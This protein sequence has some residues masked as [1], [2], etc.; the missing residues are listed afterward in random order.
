MRQNSINFVLM[1]SAMFFYC[2]SQTA[3]MS[4]C[5]GPYMGQKPP[6]MTPEVFAPGFISTDEYEVNSIFSS[7]GSEFYYCVVLNE[8]DPEKEGAA[9]KWTRQINGVWTKPALLPIAEGYDVIDIAFS[10]HGNRLYFCSDLPSI[11][12]TCEGYD[13]WY[14]ERKSGG[15]SEPI[16][17]GPNVNSP[18]GETQP[19]FTDNGDMYFPSWRPGGVGEV[20][21]YR[22]EF[23][24]GEFAEA[25]LLDGGVNSIH[26]EGN[27]FVAPDGKF[28]LYF[29]WAMPENIDGG[30][31]LYI[32]FRRE[33]GSWTESINT[34][35]KTDLYGSMAAMSPDR[36]YLFYSGQ[37]DIHWTDVRVVDLL[38]PDD[39]K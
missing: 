33:D 15:W 3:E 27:S 22:A 29:R 20:D 24:D 25:R 5:I 31:S 19:S 21:I 7:D 30:K 39:L 18:Y 11:W 8:G 13:I 1:F 26:N 4:T 12:E 6:G 38:K 17:A 14:I 10:P 2:S 23:I 28:I 32:S 36:K 34:R 9:M 35:P 37:R 16:N